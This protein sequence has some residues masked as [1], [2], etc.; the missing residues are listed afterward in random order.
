MNVNAKKYVSNGI[1]LT[2]ILV[3]MLTFASCGAPKT[4]EA[5]VNEDQET[6]EQIEQVGAAQGLDVEIKEN[7]ITYTYKYTQTFTADQL[8]VMKTSLQQAMD[9]IESSFESII[10]QLET[11][12]E[13]SG[14]T[15]SVI[16]L[17]GDG[18][19]IYKQDF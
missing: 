15:I 4:L 2:L 13:I 16:Y 10:S 17:N 8:T 9:S 18:A 1:I 6:K 12:T 7:N 3:L 14:I 5:Y 19:E 11:A